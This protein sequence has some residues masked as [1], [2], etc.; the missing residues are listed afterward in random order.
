VI[1]SHA[2]FIE[3]IYMLM[4][5]IGDFIFPNRK[6]PEQIWGIE[7]ENFAWIDFFW[8]TMGRSGEVGKAIE[9]MYDMLLVPE[10]RKRI[11]RRLARAGGRD[12]FRWMPKA[13]EWFCLILATALSKRLFQ[14][15]GLEKTRAGEVLSPAATRGLKSYI[16]GPLAK[17]LRKEHQKALNAQ[18]TFVFG[19]THKPFSAEMNFSNF[20]DVVNVYN[21]GGWVVDT[22]YTES[23]HGG[24][25]ILVDEQ[26][27][28]ASLRMYNEAEGQK[29]CVVRVEALDSG[30][31]PL[32][33]RISRLVN[34]NQ[35]PWLS[36]SA[37]VARS[38]GEYHE[39]FRVRLNMVRSRAQHRSNMADMSR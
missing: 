36:F 30:D 20:A 37:L 5:T 8:S 21:S 4:T 19:H 13:G 18:T 24:A 27:N 6:V 22:K 31:N 28:V 32:Y 39:R 3:S 34:C 15:G 17:Q 29:T 12:W 23:A 7:T 11:V 14:M 9:Q 38:V 33:A 25:I 26:M 10:A 35:D 16:E 1:F 2:H